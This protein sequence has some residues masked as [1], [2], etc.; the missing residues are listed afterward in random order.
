MNPIFA[1]FKIK[2]WNQF[3]AV[4]SGV[5]LI[6]S[7]FVPVQAIPQIIVISSSFGTLLF[8]IADWCQDK[9]ELV[10]IYGVPQYIPIRITGKK[11]YAVKFI[12]FLFISI[13]IIIKI[14][15]CGT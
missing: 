11:F 5:A 4:L 15:Q 8:C 1:K 14:I 9:Y 7:L 13:P 6:T 3:G 12:S 2:T 10:N